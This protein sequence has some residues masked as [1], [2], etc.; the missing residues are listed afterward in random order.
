MS[1]KNQPLIFFREHPSI[2]SCVRLCFSPLK[3]M[4]LTL[5]LNDIKSVTIHSID[6]KNYK[7]DINIKSIVFDYFYGEKEQV[8]RQKRNRKSWRQ[9]RLYLSLYPW[10][11]H[12]VFI[13]ATPT[14][15]EKIRCEWSAGLSLP[16]L[17]R[18]STVEHQVCVTRKYSRTG[19]LFEIRHKKRKKRER[20]LPLGC[21]SVGL[22][23]TKAVIFNPADTHF[24]E[25]K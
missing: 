22:Q 21:T 6:T 2:K 7:F 15:N 24:L 25:R 4:G 17:N 9:L 14:G 5:T 18:K 8:Q 19:R 20:K 16:P 10:C 11:R 12:F 3:Q 13:S 1:N 23:D